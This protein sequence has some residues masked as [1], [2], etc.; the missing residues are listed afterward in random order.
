MDAK[1]ARQLFGIKVISVEEKKMQTDIVL[2]NLEDRDINQIKGEK[3]IIV[4][5]SSE[6]IKLICYLKRSR[7]KEPEK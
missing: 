1:K 6:H 3:Y 5:Q 7:T 2:L 4:P